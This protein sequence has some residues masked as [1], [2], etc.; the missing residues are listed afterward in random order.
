MAET[1]TAFED[2]LVQ[3][4]NT[5]EFK[6][7]W[8]EFKGFIKQK[9]NDIINDYDADM[10]TTLEDNTKYKL[11]MQDLE[12]LNRAPFTIQ[13]ICELLLDPKRHYKFNCEKFLFSFHKLVNLD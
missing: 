13:R 11:L 2:E 7:D 4:S 5:G 10:F 9:L 8:K 12:K 1:K 3:C 6:S